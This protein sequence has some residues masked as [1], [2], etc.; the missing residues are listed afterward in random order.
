MELEWTAG[1]IAVPM[2]SAEYSLLKNALDSGSTPKG[3][4]ES[5][6][7]FGEVMV[8]SVTFDS[9]T[10]TV[11]MASFDFRTLGPDWNAPRY[12]TLSPF[13][14]NKTKE[15]VEIRNSAAAKAVADARAKRRY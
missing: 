2:D 4:F 6:G 7:F 11:C 1:K 15:N 9:P 13:F 10:P 5:F 12:P 14:L 8:I 3:L